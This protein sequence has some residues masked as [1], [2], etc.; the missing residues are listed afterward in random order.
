MMQVEEDPRRDIA[1]A[2]EAEADY[3]RRVAEDYSDDARNMLAAT[4][5][6]AAAAYALFME[7]P[8]DAATVEWNLTRFSGTLVGNSV[9]FYDGSVGIA[10]DHPF[11]P[12]DVDR[13]IV[14]EIEQVAG[15]V[16]LHRWVAS[17]E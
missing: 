9:T 4:W 12:A 1:D 7:L 11:N 3:R 8:P 2:L 6:D 5:F 15:L 13:L 14:A 10:L 17:E 16:A